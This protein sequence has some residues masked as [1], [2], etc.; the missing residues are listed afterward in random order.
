MKTNNSHK[1]PDYI[2]FQRHKPFTDVLSVLKPPITYF[3]P[4]NLAKHHR[5]QINTK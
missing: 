1:N 5:E 3:I 2:H 4:N